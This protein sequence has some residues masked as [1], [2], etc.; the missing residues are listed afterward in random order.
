MSLGLEQLL[1]IKI[2]KT[3]EDLVLQLFDYPLSVS[4][5]ALIKLFLSYFVTCDSSQNIEHLFS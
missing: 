5:A 1:K 3:E 4:S 2:K